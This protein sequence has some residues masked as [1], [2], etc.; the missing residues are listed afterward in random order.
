ME[1]GDIDGFMKF[2]AKATGASI[3]R[4]DNPSTERHQVAKIKPEHMLKHRGFMKEARKL[5]DRAKCL[6]AE[7]NMLHGQLQNN[8]TQHWNWIYQVC[9]IPSDGSYD[10]NK[11]GIIRKV[12]PS[13]KEK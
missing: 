13:S 2:F 8:D 6:I 7:L 1:E 10:M 9:E 12:V 11:E 5:Q 4:I 3:V